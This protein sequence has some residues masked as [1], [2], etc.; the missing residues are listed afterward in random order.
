MDTA[1]GLFFLLQEFYNR[2][3]HAGCHLDLNE[4]GE[5]A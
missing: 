3:S 1:K 2:Q 4:A 5:L